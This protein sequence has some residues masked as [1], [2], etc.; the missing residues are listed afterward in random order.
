M[1]L[2]SP[3]SASGTQFAIIRRCASVIL[4]AHSDQRTALSALI[5]GDRIMKHK[6]HTQPGPIPKENRPRTPLTGPANSG[7]QRKEGGGAPFQEQDPKRRL[8]NYGTAGEHP[9][10]QPGGLNDA[11][12]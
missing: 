2:A 9:Y 8:G 7:E 5:S 11:N 12:H 4:P 3:C 1:L 6:R 10:Q